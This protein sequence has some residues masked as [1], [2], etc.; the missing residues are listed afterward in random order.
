MTRLLPLPDAGFSPCVQAGM[1]EYV[2][3]VL[4]KGE[5]KA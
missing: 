2:D 4:F 5:S 1:K 3:I